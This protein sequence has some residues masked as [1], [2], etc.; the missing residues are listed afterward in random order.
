MLLIG[1]IGL[2]LLFGEQ[3]GVD[4]SALFIRRELPGSASVAALAV[5]A[6]VVTMALAQLAGDRVTPA[7]GPDH[8]GA[9]GGEPSRC[10]PTRSA[11]PAVRQRRGLRERRRGQAVA[12]GRSVLVTTGGRW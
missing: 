12:G 1:L 7:V 10:E 11:T 3:A 4:W 2:C 5:S 8:H 6:F 9:A